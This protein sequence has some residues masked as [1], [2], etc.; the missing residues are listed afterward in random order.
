MTG[1]LLTLFDPSIPVDRIGEWIAALACGEIVPSA[2][3]CQAGSD[4]HAQPVHDV[5]AALGTSP[6]TGLGNTAAQARLAEI[7]A[8]TLPPPRAR[9]A[10]AMLTDQVRTLPMGMLVASGVISLL[11]GGVIEAAV[12]LG[13]VGLNGAVGAVIESRS[14]RIIRSLGLATPEPVPLLRDGVAQLVA[15]DSVVPGDLLALRPG[16]IVP[17]DARVVASQ[18]LYVSEA[19]LTGESL[20]LAKHPAPVA[21]AVKLTERSSMVYRGTA[22]TSGTGGAIVVA[23]GSRTEIGRIQRLLHATET[24]KTP[25]QHHLDRLGG[26]LAWASIAASAAVFGLGALQGLA[27]L[28]LLR[29]SVSLAVAAIPEGLPAVATTTL[30]LGIE[31]MRGKGVLVRRLDA[32]E[33]LAS[34]EVICFDKTGTLT[35]GQMR[36]A[37]LETNGRRFRAGNDGSLRDAE[38]TVLALSE[39]SDA[40]LAGLLRVAALCN[41]A[42]MAQH[43]GEL[44]CTGSATEGALLRLALNAGLDLDRVRAAHP[45]LATRHRSATYRFMATAHETGGDEALLAVKGSPAEVLELCNW[46]MQDGTRQRLTTERRAAILGANERMASDALRVLGF[47]C[48]KMPATLLRAAD[49]EPS[50][51]E[52]PASGL[53]WLGLVGLADLLRPG[54]DALVRSLHGAGL[55]TVMMTGDQV[56]TARAIAESLHLA[57]QGAI[58][59]LDTVLLEGLDDE[60]MAGRVR[61]AHVFARVT[62]AQKLLIV[63][64]LQ[65]SGTRV[66]VVGDGTN[67]SPALR[68]ADVGIAMGGLA[69][70]EAAREAADVVLPTN[71]LAA[72]PIAIE[73][74][75]ATYVNVRKGIRYMIST[76]V[77]EVLVVLG[78]TAAQLGTPLTVMQ[79]LWINLVSDVLPALGFA[80][81]PP[82]PG[83]LQRPPF[84]ETEMFGHREVRQLGV[85]G[86]VMA[87]GGLAALALGTARHGAGARAQTMAFGSL[88]TAQ[89][90][91]ALTTRSGGRHASPPNR[92]LTGLLAG[93]AAIQ[94]LGLLVPGLRSLLGVAPLGP[95]DLLATASFGVLPYLANEA[96][97]AASVYPQEAP[98]RAS[99]P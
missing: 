68:G 3:L 60:A 2:Q 63:R 84:R 65:R 30:A 40:G 92:P 22:V 14:E 98:G 67:D 13:L 33:T 95:L 76:N 20:P 86:A 15:P 49:D 44:V 78:A 90:L 35:L 73:R 24:P 96:G 53:T 41:D 11:S 77:S 37:C 12:I 72:L 82:E 71:D 43:G 39:G 26:Q 6:V 16:A 45:R 9:S 52:L 55:R 47:A 64:A 38:G 93:S 97:K 27:L 8:N 81:E 85:E 50:A 19:M 56:S 54:M 51:P 59:V 10:L 46:E 36:V 87:A 21:Q 99:A 5:A 31:D 66:A 25:L 75:R 83:L 80:F 74:G 28:N 34:V 69:S 23:T 79:L 58:E 7:G 17:A 4:W 32:I 1:T 88:V 18:Q 48:G 70:S 89:L 61:R 91:H 94:G 29:S 57:K 62:P 42:E